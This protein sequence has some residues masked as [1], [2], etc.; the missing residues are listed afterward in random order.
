MFKK[1]EPRPSNA[2][3]RKGTPNKRT[4]RI[5]EVLEKHNFNVIEE[6]IELYSLTKNEEHTVSTAAKLLCEIASYAY[7]KLKAIEHT[8]PDG[9]PVEVYR[10]LQDLP[11]KE[12]M[13][14]L[15][16]AIDVVSRKG[17]DR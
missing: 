1:G 8:G 7:P 12:L 5:H 17:K 3:R 6:M 15:P 9:G 4:E 10:R 14:L 13:N 2:G 16:E 11:E